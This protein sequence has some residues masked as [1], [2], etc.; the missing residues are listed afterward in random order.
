MEQLCQASRRERRD[1]SIGLRVVRIVEAGEPVGDDLR[2]G[3]SGRVSGLL[4]GKLF[5]RRSLCLGCGN[6][7][8]EIVLCGSGGSRRVSVMTENLF[9]LIEVGCG[10]KLDQR[11]RLV[12]RVR[13]DGLDRTHRKTARINLVAA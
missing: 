12:V 1:L 4:I 3:F 10:T 9:E 6:S 7:N 11:V 5:G 8:R 13:L 2:C